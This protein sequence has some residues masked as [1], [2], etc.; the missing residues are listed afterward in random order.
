V[1]RRVAL[2]HHALLV[3]R[4]DEAGVRHGARHG[5]GACTGKSMES[6]GVRFMMGVQGAC[7]LNVSF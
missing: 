5:A 4:L 2:G 1:V 6:L 3:L 7:V